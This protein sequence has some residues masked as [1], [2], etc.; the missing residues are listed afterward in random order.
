MSNLN[1]SKHIS[2][3]I[4]FENKLHKIIYK[5]DSL[6]INIDFTNATN[7]EKATYNKLSKRYY[8]LMQTVNR[9]DLLVW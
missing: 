1:K 4:S 6:A 7:L 8:K 2:K 5:S 3:L 9:L